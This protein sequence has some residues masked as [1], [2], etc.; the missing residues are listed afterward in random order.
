[1]PKSWM[2]LRGIPVSLI[3]HIGGTPISL[4]SPNMDEPLWPN[5]LYMHLKGCPWQLFSMVRHFA[6][7]L[8]VYHKYEYLVPF[9]GFKRL[10]F[11]LGSFNDVYLPF[12]SCVINI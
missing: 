7:L 11:L 2:N 12:V 3:D 5:S 1:M 10:N 4:I 9:R 6:F 8:F